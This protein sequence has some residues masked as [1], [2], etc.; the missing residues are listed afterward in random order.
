MDDRNADLMNNLKQNEDSIDFLKKL[1]KE[2]PYNLE[3]YMVIGYISKRISKY[4]DALESFYTFI[5]K[6]Q[7]KMNMVQDHM[8]TY[9]YQKL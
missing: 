7:K 9:R 3:A 6:M 1:L 8:Y 5:K 4:E 2:N